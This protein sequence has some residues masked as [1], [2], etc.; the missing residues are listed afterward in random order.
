L[1]QDIVID[2]NII[3]SSSPR[4][5]VEV[6]FKLLEMLL[7]AHDFTAIRSFFQYTT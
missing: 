4:T 1:D 3:T 5:G 6:A 2:Q 7:P